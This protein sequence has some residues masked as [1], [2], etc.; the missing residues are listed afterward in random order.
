MAK[1]KTQKPWFEINVKMAE[2]TFVFAALALVMSLGLLY[3][4]SRGIFEGPA[5]AAQTYI[6]TLAEDEEKAYMQSSSL[7]KESTSQLEFELF[8]ESYPTLDFAERAVFESNYSD[9]KTHV[10]SGF[11]S[12]DSGSLPLLIEM[13]REDGAWRMTYMAIEQDN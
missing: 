10:L 8:I 1:K 9:G 5:A 13:T 11:A 6:L 12:D 2:I 3:I 7:F 4:F